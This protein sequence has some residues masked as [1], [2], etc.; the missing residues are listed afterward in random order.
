[1]RIRYL[2]P[3]GQ[4][5]LTQF[6]YNVRKR[7]MPSSIEILRDIVGFN[8]SGE[9]CHPFKGRVGVS[10][11]KFSINLK[12]QNSRSFAA[13]TEDILRSLLEKGEFNEKGT[14][15]MVPKDAK[16]SGGASALRPRIYKGKK[17]P[18]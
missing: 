6:F 1:M 2:F 7:T 5:T 14:I 12:K 13:V 10:K 18:L 11:G 4:S 3:F 9:T 8:R 16:I 17:L 15:R